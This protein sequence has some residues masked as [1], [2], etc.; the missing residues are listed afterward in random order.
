MRDVGAILFCVGAGIT[1]C[2]G[3]PVS[4]NKPVL[5]NSIFCGVMR[6][7]SLPIKDFI[8]SAISFH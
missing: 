1:E 8:G 4:K 7:F 3:L 2:L 5:A 6:Y